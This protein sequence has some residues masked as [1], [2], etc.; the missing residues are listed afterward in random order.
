MKGWWRAREVHSRFGSTGTA[1]RGVVGGYYFSW[2]FNKICM[3]SIALLNYKLK[4]QRGPSRASRTN[5]PRKCTRSRDPGAE[6]KRKRERDGRVPSPRARESADMWEKWGAG[7][8]R[9]RNLQRLMTC[10]KRRRGGRKMPRLLKV[11]NA[12]ITTWNFPLNTPFPHWFNAISEKIPDATRHS[13]N[14][15]LSRRLP[16]LRRCCQ[17]LDL[18]ILVLCICNSG[19]I[20]GID[21]PI[22][23]QRGMAPPCW[24]KLM[25]ELVA[26]LTKGR[27]YN[28]QWARESIE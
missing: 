1:S 26:W 25:E 20:I 5:G 15:P 13:F 3:Y 27:K 11:S 18:S 17:I 16:N 23:R 2:K 10:E 4:R 14:V 9:I 6:A 8:G 21:R 12:N 7:R 28:F 22:D 19:L 24:L